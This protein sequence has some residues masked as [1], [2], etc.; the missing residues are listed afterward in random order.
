MFKHWSLIFDQATLMSYKAIL[1]SYDALLMFSNETLMPVDQVLRDK[2]I[3]LIAVV[4]LPRLEENLL[5]LDF[6]V[7]FSEAG[8][9]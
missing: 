4:V 3:I 6:T 1:I 5:I 9:R 7:L 8:L 2:E